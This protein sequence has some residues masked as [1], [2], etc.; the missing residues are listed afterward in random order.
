MR[1]YLS[2]QTT[3]P[4]ETVKVTYP[5]PQQAV[6]EVNLESPGIV[7]LA[8]VYY[9]G[10]ELDDRRQASTYLQGERLDARSRGPGGISSARLYVCSPIIP[11]RRTR[12]GRRPRLTRMLGARVRDLAC[13][14][15]VGLGLM[16]TTSLRH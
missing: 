10:W 1:P 12:V 16:I 7:I 4:S 8:D 6:L 3:R 15:G 14:S 13:R 5:N 9:P 2:G 11:H